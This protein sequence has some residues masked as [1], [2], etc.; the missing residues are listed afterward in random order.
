MINKL[1]IHLSY[2]SYTIVKILFAISLL[3]ISVIGFIFG[4]PITGLLG[5]IYFFFF[6]LYFGF[7]LFYK[8]TM[9]VNTEGYKNNKYLQSF[10]NKGG[11]TKLSIVYRKNLNDDEQ[12]D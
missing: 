8:I 6:G 11:N 9:F 4:K 12:E 5:F 3:T 7:W 10:L 1:F 2:Y